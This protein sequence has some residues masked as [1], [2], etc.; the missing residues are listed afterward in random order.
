MTDSSEAAAEWARYI[1]GAGYTPKTIIIMTVASI[2]RYMDFGTC[3][4]LWDLLE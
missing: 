2:G 3:I 1:S 4:D